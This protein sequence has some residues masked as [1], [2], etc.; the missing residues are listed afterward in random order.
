MPRLVLSSVG[1]PGRSNVETVAVDCTGK[2]EALGILNATGLHTLHP[3][4]TQA[5]LGE[6][7]S[8]SPVYLWSRAPGGAWLEFRVHPLPDEAW[9]VGPLGNLVSVCPTCNSSMQREVAD[10]YHT[11]LCPVCGSTS[12]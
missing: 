5:M 8:S 7:G 11:W 3:H 6:P 1:F 4:Y 12:E 9:R 2:C 10:D